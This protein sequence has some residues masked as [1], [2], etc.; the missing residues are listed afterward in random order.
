[1]ADGEDPS[2]D[3]EEEP[4]QKKLNETREKGQVAMSR[5][6]NNWVIL[7]ASL[8]LIVWMSGAMM[9]R[10]LPMLQNFIARPDQISIETSGGVGDILW[11]ASVETLQALLPPLGM[12]FVLGFIISFVQVGPM[13]TTEPLTPKWSKLSPIAGLG[14][15]LSKKTV[16]EFLK[17]LA[18]LAIIGFVVANAIKPFLASGDAT[19]D[20]APMALM[21]ILREEART[22]FV[23]V[24]SVYFVFAL[25][26]YAWQRYTFSQQLKMSK[27]EIKDEYKQSEGDP[28]IKA[29]LAQLRQQRAR[30]RMIQRVPEA[31]VI[32]TNPTHFAIALKYDREKM[33]APMVIA[34]GMDL[35]ALKIREIA[36]ENNVP[37]Q[38]NPPLA[39]GLFD[40]VEVDQ[41][42][43]EQ[44]YKAVAE[45]I[46]YVF[47]LKKPAHQRN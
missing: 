14:R 38:E 27:Q 47:N 16:V 39:R 24:L 4:T 12:I 11:Q 40:A 44:F 13:L 36:K 41:E 30:K 15:L 23:A 7:A 1:M 22:I 6:L 19:I 17:S 31:D 28:K 43:P 9:A 5:E 33:G 8:A 20:M 26:D 29:K 37:I 10:L 42:I 2:E 45:I 46:S 34:K 18:K 35:I 32:I 3:K 21:A 25:G